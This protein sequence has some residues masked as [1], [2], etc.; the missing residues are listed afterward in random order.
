MGL[1]ERI[2]LT[3]P[4][5]A[6]AVLFVI[7]ITNAITLLIA[8]FTDQPGE[9]AARVE[10]VGNT[11]IRV[12]AIEGEDVVLGDRAPM[13]IAGRA[14]L[15]PALDAGEEPFDARPV[16]ADSVAVY[17]IFMDHQ[18][19]EF[20]PHPD[21]FHISPETFMIGDPATVGVLAIDR[22]QVF[23]ARDDEYVRIDGVEI[24][25]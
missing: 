13:D 9:D 10:R 11:R 5:L 6:G 25:G 15:A 3:R 1:L 21:S 12:M 24:P 2:D 18:A 22:H 23:R 7:E 8:R 17:F 19:A 4:E 20:V 16:S 14:D